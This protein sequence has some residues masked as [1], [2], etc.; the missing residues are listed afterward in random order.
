MKSTFVYQVSLNVFED[1]GC[2]TQANMLSIMLALSKATLGTNTQHGHLWTQ[3][4]TRID[5][6][7][8]ED[9]TAFSNQHGIDILGVF[10]FVHFIMIPFGSMYYTRT[11]V[12]QVNLS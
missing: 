5:P 4:H 11:I 7:M 2:G 3:V 1:L 9:F 12:H 6:T 8:T 10:F